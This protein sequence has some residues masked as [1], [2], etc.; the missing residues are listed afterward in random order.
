[1]FV[2]NGN[3]WSELQEIVSGSPSP[4]L[5]E[6]GHAVALDGTTALLGSFLGEGAYI[7]E[8]DGTSWQEV[9]A[10]VPALGT[11]GDR[12]GNSVAVSDGWILVGAPARPTTYVFERSGGAWVERG[13][14]VPPG[15]VGGDG[16]SVAIGADLGLVGKDAN[17][18][19]VYRLTPPD[20]VSYCT[21]KVSLQ[22]CMPTM[23]HV[24]AA[25]ESSPAPFDVGATQVI[26]NKNG[27]LYYGISAP[28]AFPFQG[29]SCVCNRL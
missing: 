16:D 12:F 14:L 23:M 3:S 15:T 29:E 26:N 13:Q 11:R 2:R 9:Q 4:S 25:S 24:G 20:P 5:F 6:F 22:G 21:A 7:F 28:A 1:M 27:L 19:E 17:E 8:W 18:V 10:L